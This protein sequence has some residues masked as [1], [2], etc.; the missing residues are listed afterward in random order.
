SS[1]LIIIIS[2]LTQLISSSTHLII[3]SSSTQLNSSHH[4]LIIISSH[5]LII[6][7]LDVST[8]N[9]LLADFHSEREG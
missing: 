2:S 7:S 1:L 3:I 5:H 6:N 8:L 4:H 9:I